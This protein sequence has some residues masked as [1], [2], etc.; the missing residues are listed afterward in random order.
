LPDREI[1]Y[2][3][4]EAQVLVE[5][6]RKGYNTFRPDSSYELAIKMI[7]I[8]VTT[9]NGQNPPYHPFAKGGREDLLHSR[10]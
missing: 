10:W 9:N 6:V 1:L 2:I 8:P 7:A 5:Q 3:L 4:K